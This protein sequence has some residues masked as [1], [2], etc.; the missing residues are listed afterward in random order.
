MTPLPAQKQGA[1]LPWQ[2]GQALFEWLLKMPASQPLPDGCRY[3]AQQLLFGEPAS[4]SSGSGDHDAPPP[5]GANTLEELAVHIHELLLAAAR[6][7]GDESCQARVQLYQFVRDASLLP[8][9][10]PL[11]EAICAGRDEH[12]AHGLAELARWLVRRAAHRGPLKLGL[13]L[14]GLVGEPADVPDLVHLARHD[15][16]TLF[17]AVAAG[18]ILDEPCETWWRMAQQNYGAGR[19]VLVERLS[20]YCS[21]SPEVRHWL[22]T[23]GFRVEGFEAELALHCAKGARLSAVL[24]TPAL[25]PDVLGAAC[26]LM[27]HLLRSTSPQHPP[28][29]GEY[30]E[31]RFAVAHLLRHLSQQPAAALAGAEVALAVRAWLESHHALTCTSASLRRTLTQQCEGLLSR[32]HWLR[33]V[34]TAVRTGT[35]AERQRAFDVAAG[36]GLDLWDETLERFNFVPLTAPWVRRLAREQPQ[37]RL[38]ELL[39]LGSKQLPHDEIATGPA[40]QLRL[41]EPGFEPHA[42]LDALLG[43]IS[44]D[45]ITLFE[46]RLIATAIRSPVV[47]NRYAALTILQYVPRALWGTNVEQAL[48]HVRFCEPD[49]ELAEQWQ[50]LAEAS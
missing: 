11:T 18:R 28:L 35:E 15:E 5:A 22:L 30:P 37:E 43:V 47:R 46:P 7:A 36:L 40:E 21:E 6:S 32:S 24:A 20:T 34:S 38:L 39:R 17:A 26:E 13:V 8:L 23:E 31:A 10:D 27:R 9:A 41:D 2:E 19:V 45:A 29:I 48:R 3:D 12:D 4:G 14:L 33:L 25:P 1:T 44:N 42:A 16:F 50:R 49:V